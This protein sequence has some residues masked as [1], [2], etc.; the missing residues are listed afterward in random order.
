MVC[1]LQVARPWDRET[2]PQ[3][4]AHSDPD[5]FLPGSP[6]GVV[7]L[8]LIPFK[9]AE[10]GAAMGRGSIAAMAEAAGNPE[11]L[12][13]LNCEDDSGG[14]AYIK[15]FWCL[16]RRGHCV[17]GCTSTAARGPPSHLGPP[18]TH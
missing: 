11:P 15:V 4:L 2:S 13:D 1:S 16:P 12:P 9:D 14:Q 8:Y 18:Y 6:H 5:P 7:D 10:D 3:R 17:D